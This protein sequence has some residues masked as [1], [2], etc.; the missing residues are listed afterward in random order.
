MPSKKYKKKT[1]PTDDNDNSTEKTSSGDISS[2]TSL[3]SDSLEY[4]FGDDSSFI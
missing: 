4:D 1:K 2:S 3:V